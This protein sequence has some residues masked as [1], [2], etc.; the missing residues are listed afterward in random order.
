[1]VICYK[2]YWNV[3][4]TFMKPVLRTMLFFSIGPHNVSQLQKETFYKEDKKT[5]KCIKYFVILN[6]RIELKNNWFGFENVQVY[7]YNLN[8]KPDTSFETIE[9]MVIV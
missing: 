2:T 6:D 1:M 7:Y 5:V 4:T 3:H 9:N 8:Q